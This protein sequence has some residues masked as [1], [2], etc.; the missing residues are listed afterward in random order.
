MKF[1]TDANKNGGTGV[2][3]WV[4]MLEAR[5]WPSLEMLESVIVGVGGFRIC[6]FSFFFFHFWSCPLRGGRA[7]RPDTRYHKE[8]PCLCFMK[9]AGDAG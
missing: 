5:V 4:V 8:V 6:S 7:I 3:G 2:E 1:P 9:W